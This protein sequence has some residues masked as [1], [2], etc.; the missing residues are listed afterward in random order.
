MKDLIILGSTGSIGTQALE[1]VDAYPDKLRVVGLCCASNSLII[2]QIEKY[3]PKYVAVQNSE[4]ADKI[5]RTFNDVEVYIGDDGICNLAEKK[6]DVV[7]NA[8]V[9]ISG[10]RPTLAAIRAGNDI[11]LANKET[12][13]RKSVV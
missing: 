7:L 4:L 8:L 5:T 10:L 2:E 9:G 3:A 13:D 1:V 6:V 12:L 11:A